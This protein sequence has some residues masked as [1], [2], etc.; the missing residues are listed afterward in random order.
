MA[1][2]APEHAG[3]SSRMRTGPGHGETETMTT[4]RPIDSSASASAS[5]GRVRQPGL[6]GRT[7]PTAAA[8]GFAIL[9]A[10][11]LAASGCRGHARMRYEEQ[12]Q[13][14]MALAPQTSLLVE[15]ARGSVRLEPGDSGTVRIEAHKRAYAFSER[16]ARKLAGEV[17]V[18]VDRVG[19]RMEV[20]VEYPPRTVSSTTH[21]E[22]FGEDVTRRRAEVDLVVYVPTG[23][24]TRV[25]TRS[26]DLSVDG[27][28]G[29]LEFGTTS[30]DAEIEKHAGPVSIRST[31][32]DVT[33]KQCEGDLDMST[34]S[35]DLDVAH[36]GGALR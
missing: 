28:T 7:L 33:G 36:V 4:S 20:H 11:A 30:G 1:D 2:A 8:G 29:P 34:T 12:S 10:L 3:R 25:E 5:P 16:E 32:G 24:P 18:S 26:A 22:V 21:V 14:S 15:N 27:T 9:A 17:N 31:S 23:T 19:G 35:G 13:T 6:P